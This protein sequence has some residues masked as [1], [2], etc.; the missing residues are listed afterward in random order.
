[1]A[2]DYHERLTNHLSRYKEFHMGIM[3]GEEERFNRNLS[4]PNEYRELNI[5]SEFRQPFKKYSQSNPLL[6]LDRN[7]HHLISTQALCF[8]LF[9][10]FVQDEN[11]RHIL[12]DVLGSKNNEVKSTGFDMSFGRV[13]DETFDFYMTSISG[14][15]WYFHI[16]F[17]ETWFGPAHQSGISS[18][19]L[20][21]SS[22]AD[23]V[24]LVAGSVLK[25]PEV[26]KLIV[27]LKKLSFVSCS[28]NRSLCCIFPK[29][30]SKLVEAMSLLQSSLYD[31]IR[32]RLKV[33]Y[34]E[35]FVESILQKSN[36]SPSVKQHYFHIQKKY[37]V[38]S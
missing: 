15:K 8:N 26:A 36:N 23:I 35:D 27:L 3:T 7:F 11:A 12:L 1:M 32:S 29:A 37:I 13:S 10:H 22:R 17:A 34:L 20:L 28:E 25:S 19:A 24:G 31:T 14:E 9:I 5:L 16:K 2:R 38:P 18:E 4:L 21:A 33:I 6:Q 30:N